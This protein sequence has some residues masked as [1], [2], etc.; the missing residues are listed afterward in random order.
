[1][2]VELATA[3]WLALDPIEQLNIPLLWTAF[4]L[5]LII[6]ISTFMLQVPA[7][8]SL[9][10]TWNAATH[11]RLVL[12]NWIRTVGW[13]VRSVLLSGVLLDEFVE[14]VK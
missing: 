8:Q 3:F 9:S 10:T 12:T 11:K 6:W 7:H 2:T 5:L 4:V 1:M 13:S 14:V